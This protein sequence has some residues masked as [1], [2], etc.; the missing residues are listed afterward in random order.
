M[1]ITTFTCGTHP[2]FQAQWRLTEGHLSPNEA[3]EALLKTCLQCSWR[4]G[5]PYEQSY[6]AP[7]QDQLRWVFQK[8]S[9][10]IP[11]SDTSTPLIRH[12]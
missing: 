6:R 11:N 12:L 9:A 4:A 5:L 1:Y 8:Y 2:L 10:G 7:Y 3:L